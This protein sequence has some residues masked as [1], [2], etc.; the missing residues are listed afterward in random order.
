MGENDIAQVVD[1]NMDR[2]VEA[3]QT[4]GPEGARIFGEMA[5]YIQVESLIKTIGLTTAL[6]IGW[7]YAIA[8]RNSVKSVP[9]SEERDA[10]T[11][12]LLFIFSALILFTV[13]SFD[14]IGKGVAN[15]FHPER[16][17]IMDLLGRSG[18]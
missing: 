3:I 12:V 5:G 16:A 15:I 18:K 2:M 13:V 17:V 14:F 10:R 1:K 6:I 9:P 7:I 8:Q 4:L 11:F